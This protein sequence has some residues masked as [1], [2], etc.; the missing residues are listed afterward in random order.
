MAELRVAANQTRD[1][2]PGLSVLVDT[3]SATVAGTLLISEDQGQSFKLHAQADRAGIARVL[4]ANDG[5]LILIG[6][7]GVKRLELPGPDGET[8]P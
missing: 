8:E 7:T 3:R 4:Q 6:E 1:L 2:R 5:A